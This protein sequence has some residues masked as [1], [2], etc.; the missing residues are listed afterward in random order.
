M[1]KLE[2]LGIIRLGLDYMTQ[3]ETGRYRG[4][5]EG[6]REWNKRLERSIGREY[7]ARE[8]RRY[9]IRKE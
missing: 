3:T 8:F 4:F 5:K 2:K 9:R 1:S 7:N 6:M